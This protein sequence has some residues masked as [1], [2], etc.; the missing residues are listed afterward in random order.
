M[1]DID[2]EEMV[3][4]LSDEDSDIYSTV[5][6]RGYIIDINVEINKLIEKKVITH[7]HII[8][9]RV[10]VTTLIDFCETSDH[11]LYN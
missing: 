7:Q 11:I 10:Y 6:Y 8:E 9:G 1:N 5:L 4:A 2:Y 3:I